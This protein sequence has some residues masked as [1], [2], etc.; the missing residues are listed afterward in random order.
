MTNKNPFEVRLD[1]MKMA[2]EML[3]KEYYAKEQKYLQKLEFLKT[4]KH[5]DIDSFIDANAP[6]PYTPEDIVMRAS[7][8][9]NFVSSSTRNDK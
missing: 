6:A 9:Y 4:E 1:V 5:P 7:T 2:Q 8:L 3:D